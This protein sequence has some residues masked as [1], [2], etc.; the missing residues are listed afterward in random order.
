MSA[1]PTD[2]VTRVLSLSRPRLLLMV[3]RTAFAPALATAV[4][5]SDADNPT[6]VGSLASM[7]K[8]KSSPNTTNDSGT[9][10]LAWVPPPQ[11]IIEAAARQ[12]ASTTPARRAE[13]DRAGKEK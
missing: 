9:K 1:R 5:I 11:L 12:V 10:R 3:V 8:A 6:V 4:S 2:T 7:I 13:R